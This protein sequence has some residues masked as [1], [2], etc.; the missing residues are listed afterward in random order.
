M[1]ADVLADALGELSGGTGPLYRRV[2]DGLVTLAETGVLSRGETLPSERELAFALGVSRTTVTGA[3]ATLRSA[4]WIDTAQGR[5][6]SI[7]RRPKMPASMSPAE[8]IDDL[9][10]SHRRIVDLSTSS[11]SAAPIVQ[12][13]FVDPSVLLGDNVGLLTEGTGYAPFGVPEL[14]EAIVDRLRADGIHAE[15]NEIVV[16]AG[17]QQALTLVANVLVGAGRTC[18]IEQFSYPGLFDAVTQN[19]AKPIGLPL[20]RSADTGELGVVVAKAQ[21]LCKAADVD[22]VFLT[23]FQNP[24][25]AKF[26]DDSCASFAR[27]VQ[28]M[29]AA[30][31]ED[32]TLADLALRTTSPVP[33]AAMDSQSQIITIGGLSKVM[34]GGLRIGWIHTNA[35]LAAHLRDKRA[36]HD[37]GSPTPLQILASR[38]LREHYE[39]TRTWRIQQLRLSCTAL[40]E[41][42]EKNALPW[43][44]SMPEGGP[45][46]WV[47]IGESTAPQFAIAAAR[48]GVPFV[49]GRAFAQQPG[50]GNDYIRIPFYHSPAELRRAVALLTQAWEQTSRASP[51]C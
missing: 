26:D 34:W 14:L 51:N 42:I 4:G 28:R 32:R 9:F 5:V 24:T 48:L 50:A 7:G 20:G 19:G 17:G 44:A 29:G 31:I 2:A 36:A 33:L 40:L 6:A 35:T 41:A 27:S 39:P 46:L 25:G 1:L 18:A 15:P 38:L 47:N 37:L 49:A 11:P 12:K 8:R 45:N 22:A 21:R 13:T 10:P 23:R 43:R 16:T 3:Y 30:I